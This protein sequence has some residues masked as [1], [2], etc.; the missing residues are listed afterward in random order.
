MLLLSAL[1]L[2]LRPAP[3]LNDGDAEFDPETFEFLEFELG[4]DVTPE[5]VK[6]SERLRLAC[7]L[8]SSAVVFQLYYSFF[9]APICLS[10]TVR[11]G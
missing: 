7:S 3:I 8:L 6:S 9:Y 10:Y 5:G 11:T 1:H 2:V 4:K